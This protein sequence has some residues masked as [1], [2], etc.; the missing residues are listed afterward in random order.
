M[1]PHNLLFFI[2]LIG[3]LGAFS[4]DARFDR[5]V[6]EEFDEL[7][8][9]RLSGHHN[10]SAENIWAVNSILTPHMW[11]EPT[12]SQARGPFYPVRLPSEIDTDLTMVKGVQARGVAVYL[13]GQVMEQN[14]QIIKNATIEIWQACASGKYDH[15]RDSNRAIADENFQYYAK[16]TTDETGK[17][18][19]KT[20]IPGPY[21]A[22]ANW[23]RPPHL[24]FLIAAPGFKTLTTQSY[25]NGD[26]FPEVITRIGDQDIN[27]TVINSYNHDDLLLGQLPA[28]EREK[29][30]VNFRKTPEL[31]NVKLGVFNIYLQKE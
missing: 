7:K 26:S 18:I 17:Y 9:F 8:I 16:T 19:F 27:G 11:V 22:D 10:H 15:P 5:L 1:R 12:P 14:G 20:I 4:H 6:N 23:Y 21:P 13:Q 29:L 25:F 28:Q 24:H 2:A 3:S 31:G 30:I